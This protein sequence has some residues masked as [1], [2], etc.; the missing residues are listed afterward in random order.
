MATAR[1]FWDKIADRYSKM[2]ISDEEAY[3][4]KLAKTREY[5]TPQSEV[6]EFACGTGGTTIKHAPFVKHIYA[7]DISKRM[8]EF[9]EEKL[10]VAN[11][12]N[13]TFEQNAIENIH[14]VDGCYDVVMGMSIL[15]LLV[16]K[17]LVIR[18]VFQMLKPGGVFVSSTICLGDYMPFFKFIVPFGRA[19]GKMPLVRSLKVNELEQS[20]INAGFTIEHRWQPHKKAAVF[21]VVRK[22][23]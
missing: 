16:N 18:K 9:C 8:I 11:V 6:L 15:H 21:F 13:V 3:R 4:K 22:A 19:I 2:S 12:D 14:P 1:R 10:K 20:F 17:D 5:L 23:V 7:I